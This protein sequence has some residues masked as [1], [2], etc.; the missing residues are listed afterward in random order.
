MLKKMTRSKL[1][2][3]WFVAVG[4]LVAAGVAMGTTMT[5][6]T[7]ALLV[8]GCLVPPAVIFMLWPGVETQTAGDVL[9]GDDRRR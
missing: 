8:A 7:G 3:I 6:G 5:F 9:R 2:Q 4:L 1:I